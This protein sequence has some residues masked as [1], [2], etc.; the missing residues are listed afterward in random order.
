M[1]QGLSR[2]LTS[3]ANEKVPFPLAASW[4]GV[5]TYGGASER[6]IKV[7]CPFEAVEHPDGG[8]EPAMRV[9]PDHGWCFAESRYFSVVSLL[10][11]VWQVPREEAAREALQR[12]GLQR[13]IH[14]A[15]LF[16]S[17]AGYQ[18]EPDQ[19]ALAAALITWCEACFPGWREA[20]FQDP[21]AGRLAQCLGLLPLVRDS[22]DCDTW[23]AAAKKAMARVLT[24][25]N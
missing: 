19:D 23:L 17:A 22:G 15:A 5:E 18:P 7:H 20:Q 25:V 3:L 1:E 24:P 4:A 9:Y 2:S 10:A 6:G 13:D 21:A 16:E 8:R 14:Y 12:A 11:E